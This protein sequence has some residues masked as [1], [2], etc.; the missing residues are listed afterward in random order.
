MRRLTLLIVVSIVTVLL[1]STVVFAAQ[2]ITGS[3]A[4]GTTPFSPSRN[5]CISV[6]S[7][8]TQF[9]ATSAH[10]N[11]NSQY[12]TCGGSG[13]AS[14]CDPAKVYKKD[15]YDSGGTVCGNI[16]GAAQDGGHIDNN[17]SPL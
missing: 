12:G 4:I 15:G 17:W 3:T 2:S 9:G 11:G 10:L 16:T 5:V 6:A 13:L 14:T 1:F 7:A 8:P